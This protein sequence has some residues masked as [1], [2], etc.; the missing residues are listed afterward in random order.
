MPDGRCRGMCHNTPGVKAYWRQMGLPLRTDGY[1]CAGY[2][3][4]RRR[5]GT[6]RVF[7]TFENGDQPKYCPCCGRNMSSKAH[8]GIPH[9]LAV[10]RMAR[11]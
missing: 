7:F 10:A 8:A 3:D 6:C 2:K 4:G 9:K 1:A 11:Y 5:C